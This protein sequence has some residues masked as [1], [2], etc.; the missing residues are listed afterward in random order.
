MIISKQGSGHFANGLN[1]QDFYHETSRMCL[2]VDGCSG[3]QHAEVGSKLF[4]QLLT[5]MED[6]DNPDKFEGNVENVFKSMDEM[7]SKHYL[8]DGK[9]DN[10]LYINEFVAKNMLFTIIALF[11]TDKGFMVKMFGDGYIF[12]VNNRGLISYLK[13]SYGKCP[14]YYAYKFFNFP[15][16]ISLRDKTFRTWHF[17]NLK[18]KS[19]GIGSDGI[20]PIVASYDL[21]SNLHFARK[22]DG[23]IKSKNFDAIMHEIQANSAAFSDDTTIGCFNDPVSIVT[24]TTSKFA[25]M[26][27]GDPETR[28]AASINEA[29]ALLNKTEHTA[30]GVSA[31]VTD[32][33]TVTNAG[34]SVADTNGIDKTERPAQPEE[35]NKNV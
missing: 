33:A 13:Y 6:Y 14:P 8:K 23:H 27:T 29:I 20:A 15:D 1:N 28:L 7:F 2:I 30:S 4:V 34:I 25:I 18:F 22:M 9:L 24:T 32:G 26:N 10:D 31:T 19:V 16:G 12:T 35:G 5:R 11:K 21:K 3:A 17:D